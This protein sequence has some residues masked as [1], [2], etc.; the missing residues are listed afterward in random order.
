MHKTCY[1]DLEPYFLSV[2][3]AIEDDLLLLEKPFP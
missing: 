1:R 2:T 3:T